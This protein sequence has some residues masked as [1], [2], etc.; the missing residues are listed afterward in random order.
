VALTNT[1]V[2]RLADL[3][4]IEMT[5]EELSVMTGQLDLILDAVAAVS[6]AASADVAPTSH[7]LDLTNVFRTDVVAPSLRPDEVLAMAPAVEEGRFR[8]PHILQEES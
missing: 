2:A 5:E 6:Q 8:V 3:A 7:A 1:D 4:R